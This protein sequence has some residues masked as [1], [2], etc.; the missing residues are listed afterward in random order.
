MN[1]KTKFTVAQQ[2]EVSG[3]TGAYGKENTIE[4]DSVGKNGSFHVYTVVVNDGKTA[5]YVDGVKV[6]TGNN[7][8]DITSFF[9]GLDVI[10]YIGKSLYAAD[11]YL[12]EQSENLRY[13]IMHLMTNRLRVR[14]RM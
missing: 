10:G 6:G 8:Y 14:Y 5:L 12:Q 1:S 7:P 2:N 3:I 9:E 13:M 4:V 11:R